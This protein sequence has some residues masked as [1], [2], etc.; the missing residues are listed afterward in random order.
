MARCYL[1][2]LSLETMR[3]MAGFAAPRSNFH[4]K[5]DIVVP[6]DLLDEVSPEAT[7]WYARHQR[8]QSGEGVETNIM[9]GGFLR[10]VL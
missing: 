7:V 4:I 8:H 3:F 10:L 5:L 9:A 6:D 1:S 2:R